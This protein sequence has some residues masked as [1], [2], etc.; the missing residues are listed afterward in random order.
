[1][2]HKPY[3]VGIS[4]G[5]ASG[6]T[7]FLNELGSLFQ[8]KEL[9]IISQDN[10]Y[11][12]ANHHKPD[13]NG[14]INYDLPECIDLDTF[15]ND[16]QQ[17]SE[18]HTIRARQYHFQHEEQF[19]DWLEFN[20]AP[21]II[22][23]GLFLFYREDLFRQFDLKVFIEANEDIKLSRRMNRDTRERNIPA[24]FVLYQ[25]ENHVTPAYQQY[26]LPYREKADL[27]INNNSHFG[28]SLKVVEDHFRRILELQK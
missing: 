22:A 2:Q 3:L 1:M 14:H 25:W 11:K 26:L 4:G 20:P 8:P 9:C 24:E 13:A 18:G 17:L 16:L 6:K 28:N 10:Y 19:G 15:S 23:E 7:R 27:I 21:I 5:S 12:T